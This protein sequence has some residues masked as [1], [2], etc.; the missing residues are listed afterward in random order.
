MG[1]FFKNEAYINVR[2]IPST[3]PTLSFVTT[4]GKF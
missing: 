2:I 3:L 1:F 4:S